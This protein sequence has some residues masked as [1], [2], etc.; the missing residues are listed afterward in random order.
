M[1]IIHLYVFTDS[2]QDNGIGVKV[3]SEREVTKSEKTYS[4]RGM[5]LHIEEFEKPIKGRSS[6]RLSC[7]I[8]T[9]EQNAKQSILKCVEVII[10]DYDEQFDVLAE[11]EHAVSKAK[12]KIIASPTQTV[13]D[14]KEESNKWNDVSD[15]LKKFCDENNFTS[16]PLLTVMPMLIEFLDKKYEAPKEK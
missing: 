16:K 7:D 11:I 12:E 3:L 13:S 4:G 14:F 1:K 2:K 9:T 15:E 8:W 10:R 6:D 5:R